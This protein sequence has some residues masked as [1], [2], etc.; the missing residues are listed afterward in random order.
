MK[1]MTLNHLFDLLSGCGGDVD[2]S[3]VNPQA[4]DTPFD[5]L[6]CDS[7]SLLETTARIKRDLGVDIPDEK[8]TEMRSPRAVIDYVNGALVR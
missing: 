1:E 2:S 8:I 6:G 3:T 5:E 7:L 4:M